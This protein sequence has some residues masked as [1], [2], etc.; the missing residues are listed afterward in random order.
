[1][2]YTKFKEILQP[3]IQ[4]LIE[5]SR[6][7]KEKF[8]KELLILSQTTDEELI[9]FENKHQ[10]IIPLFYKDFLKE[11]NPSGLEIMF[12]SI[13]GLNEIERTLGYI[14]FKLEEKNYLPIL[15]DGGGNY[16]CIEENNETLFIADHENGFELIEFDSIAR[17]FERLVEE[18]I[19]NTLEN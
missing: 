15:G 16:F 18:K 3:T 11:Y 9:A 19:S 6:E 14:N 12:H 17:F 13:Y 4:I 2:E 10:L 7:F 5:Q 8:G 1:M